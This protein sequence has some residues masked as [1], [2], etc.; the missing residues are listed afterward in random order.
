MIGWT[1]GKRD[2]DGKMA[3]WIEIGELE[4]I[5]LVLH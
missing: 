5:N 1:K 3:F 2:N 4:T